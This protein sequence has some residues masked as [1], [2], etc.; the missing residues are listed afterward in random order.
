MELIWRIQ[1]LLL[2]SEP[3]GFSCDLC[4][5]LLTEIENILEDQTIDD[6]VI[7]FFS[8]TS[9]EKYW[10]KL[11]SETC[12]IDMDFSTFVG[13]QI[14]LNTYTENIFSTML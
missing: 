11:L 4:V 9:A 7:T 8:P 12:P 5:N 1:I 6:A 3:K 13:T 10:K 2:L 14:F